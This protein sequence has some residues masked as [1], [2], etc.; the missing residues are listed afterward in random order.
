MKAPHNHQ[1]SLHAEFSY[2]NLKHYLQITY[3]NILMMHE[4]RIQYFKII[5]PISSQK[6]EQSYDTITIFKRIFT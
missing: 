1:M 3:I 2:P 6:N 4:L 5:C